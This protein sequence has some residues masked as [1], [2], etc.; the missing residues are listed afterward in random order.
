MLDNGI[1]KK[2]KKKRVSPPP[3]AWSLHLQWAQI[4][5]PLSFLWLRPSSPLPLC[6]WMASVH[7][8]QMEQQIKQLSTKPILIAPKHTGQNTP[9][10][11]TTKM[12][13]NHP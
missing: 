2:K 5:S 6:H 8:T 3:L 1:S 13:Q 9:A 10:L 4:L 7:R 11:S 12:Q